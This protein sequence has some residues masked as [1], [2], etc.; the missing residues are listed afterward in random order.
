MSFEPEGKCY[1]VHLP[2]K[3]TTYFRDCEAAGSFLTETGGSG[4]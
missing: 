4:V 2:S 3:P 1:V